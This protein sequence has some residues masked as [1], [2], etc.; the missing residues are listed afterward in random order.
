MRL[1]SNLNRMLASRLSTVL[2]STVSALALTALAAMPANSSA[3][4]TYSY[5]GFGTYTGFCNGTYGEP[6]DCLGAVTGEFTLPGA[7]LASNLDNMPI[8]PMAFSFSDGEGVTLTSVDSIGYVQFAVTTGPTGE[9]L[10]WSVILDVLNTLNH[11]CSDAPAS[12]GRV[13]GFFGSRFNG[14][15]GEFSCYNS[16]GTGTFGAGTSFFSDHPDEPQLWTTTTAVP[17]PPTAALIAAS[18]F[19]LLMMLR[20][21]R[22]NAIGPAFAGP[23]LSAA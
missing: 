8:T 3:T 21:R 4:T 13:L 12:S 10:Q 16:P 5:A 23:S 2:C 1:D 6:P 19:P 17:E 15:Y 9:L 14:Q 11:T 22:P 7:G 18:V 20:R